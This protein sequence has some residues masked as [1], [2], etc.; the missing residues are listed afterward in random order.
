MSTN[1]IVKYT[2]N[3]KEKIIS[4]GYVTIIFDKKNDYCVDIHEEVKKQLPYKEGSSDFER[5]FMD[6]FR[7]IV[8]INNIVPY[9]NIS[10][11]INGIISYRNDKIL[12]ALKD[13]Q[14]DEIVKL[15]LKRDKE[16][17]NCRKKVED[18]I[19][20][21]EEEISR[22]LSISNSKFMDI[23]NKYKQSL[24]GINIIEG[25][26]DKIK[27]QNEIDENS[28][29]LSTA[30]GDVDRLNILLAS[31]RSNK[32]AELDSEIRKIDEK[33]IKDVEKVKS[34][35]TSKIK[36]V[37]DKMSSQREDEE[38]AIRDVLESFN[39]LKSKGSTK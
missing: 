16:I 2:G 27:K 7:F 4:K 31:A 24:S 5:I 25:E 23:S 35:H 39:P 26:E 9:I 38:K 15:D 13:R 29:L 22:K 12:K 36:E 10:S 19:I 8:F 37:F 30:S 21:L 17:L 6:F 18:E 32:Y 33:Y 20:K 34:L 28:M 3:D 14:S 1:Y 11:G